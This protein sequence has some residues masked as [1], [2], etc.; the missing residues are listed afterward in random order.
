M[1]TDWVKIGGFGFVHRRF[2]D[3]YFSKTKSR[4]IREQIAEV[5]RKPNAF[6]AA[7]GAVRR[8][9]LSSYIKRKMRGKIDG[10]ICDELHQYNNNSGQGTP[11][12]RSPVPPTR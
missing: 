5:C 2:P 4:T 7:V 12:E 1:Q 9:A 11:W 6:Y 10:A 8:F 3:L